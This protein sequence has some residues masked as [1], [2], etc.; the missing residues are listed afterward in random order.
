MVAR[1]GDIAG[2]FEVE[3]RAAKIDVREKCSKAAA[4]KIYIPLLE[5]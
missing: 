3:R 5:R 1:S 4:K 2:D